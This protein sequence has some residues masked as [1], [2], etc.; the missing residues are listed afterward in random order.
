MWFVQLVAAAYKKWMEQENGCADDITA[1]IVRF[2]LRRPAD[3][4]K[5]G[6]NSP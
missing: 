5:L 1:V 2:K 3:A 4:A 6:T